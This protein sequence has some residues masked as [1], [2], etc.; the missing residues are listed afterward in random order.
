MRCLALM[1]SMR[2]LLLMLVPF[3]P[4]MHQLWLYPSGKSLELRSL[5]YRR[6]RMVLSIPMI[7]WCLWKVCLF[8]PGSNW[9]TSYYH[10]LLEI[11]S[12]GVSCKA[13]Q[14]LSLS[15]VSYFHIIE[16]QHCGCYIPF[17][18]PIPLHK[19]YVRQIPIIG[20]FRIS[21]HRAIP[22]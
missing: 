10:G 9:I 18:A 3:H 1:C 20:S 6:M 22:E 16:R 17:L 15:D 14:N 4:T 8:L 11:S 7:F 13:H 19:S 12:D 2:K 21:G 5:P